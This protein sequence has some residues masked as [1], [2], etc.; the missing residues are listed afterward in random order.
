MF[1]VNGILFNHE[2]PR[3]GETFVTRKIT[4]AVAAIK[5]G[6][7]DYALHGQPRRGPR[8]GLRRRSTSRACGGCCR[9]T[10]PTTTCW[11]PA[12]GCTVREFLEI[13]FE[14]AGLDWEEHVRFDERYLR[15][16]EV[17]ALIGDAAKAARQARLEGDRRRPRAGPAHGRRRHRGARRAPARPGSTRSPC[18]AGR[19]RERSSTTATRSPSRPARSTATPPS[20]SRATAAWWA[21]RSGA[22]SRPRASRT[23]VGK[24]S[25]ELDLK[26]RDAVFAYLGEIKPRYVVLAAAKVG[27]ILA[28]STYPVDFLSDNLRIQVNV[29]DAALAHDVE[30][31]LF[32]GS[33]CIYPK[34]AAAAD[35]RGLA[36]HRAPGADQRRL[37]DRQDR[38]HHAGAGGPPSVRPAVDLG[39]ADQPLRAERQLLTDRARTSCRR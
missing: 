14:H 3:R 13:S 20:T 24:T 9:S 25:A 15:P 5:A 10:S 23:L 31:V 35:R 2:S 4:R 16:T 8:L 18:R 6:Q 30:R 27:G 36:A 21:R 12:S 28:N 17:D 26:D 39:D 33:S 37:R 11:P 34:F 29:L 22:S 7:Q 1:A 19:P 38:R 32:L